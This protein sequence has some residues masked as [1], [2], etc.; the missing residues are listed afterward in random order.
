MHG[1]I[2]LANCGSREQS[3][4][5][6]ARTVCQVQIIVDFS[7]LQK[8]EKKYGNELALFLQVW[9]LLPPAHTEICDLAQSMIIPAQHNLFCYF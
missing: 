3:F 9:L 8:Q 6:C 5:S 7:Q 2:F 4:S 1:L